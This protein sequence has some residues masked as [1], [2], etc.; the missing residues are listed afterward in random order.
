[1]ITV[2]QI[3]LRGGLFCF[4]LDTP[5]PQFREIS[6][7]R[8]RRSPAGRSQR[9]RPPWGPHTFARQ[10]RKAGRGC[11]PSKAGLR[12]ATHT[13]SGRLWRMGRLQ[14]AFGGDAGAIRGRTPGKSRV[15]GGES[16]RLC[17]ETAHSGGVPGGIRSAAPG[18]N[19]ENRAL[20][21]LFPGLLAGFSG[22]KT[23]STGQK[24]RHFGAVGGKKGG[25][26]PPHGGLRAENGA[27]HGVLRTACDGF[28]LTARA[29]ARV[30]A[31]FARI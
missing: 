18:R 15:A 19:R 2:H 27:Q 3:V 9:L 16:G 25:K 8:G 5:G 10:S 1:M 31:R 12:A 20:P 29:L 7:E 23:G 30:Q 21:G 22:R 13:R 6:R 24:R 28:T 11:S 14:A 4:G 17:R 26:S